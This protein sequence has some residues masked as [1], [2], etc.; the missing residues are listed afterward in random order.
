MPEYKDKES[1]TKTDYA[2]AIMQLFRNNYKDQWVNEKILLGKNRIW[3]QTFNDL[4]EK[5]FILR[6]KTDLGFQYR[7]NGQFPY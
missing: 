2:H 1:N 6:K 4:I 5:G 3:T 7:W